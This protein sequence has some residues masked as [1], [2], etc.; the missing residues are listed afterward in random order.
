MGERKDVDTEG[1]KYEAMR[2][3]FVVEDATE[4]KY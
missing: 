1:V 4:P 2:F 3:C